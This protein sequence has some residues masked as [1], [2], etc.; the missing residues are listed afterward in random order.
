[1]NANISSFIKD[2]KGW[3]KANEKTSGLRA[4]SHT[5]ENI[6]SRTSS[7]SNFLSNQLNLSFPMLSK[8]KLSRIGLSHVSLEYRETKLSIMSLMIVSFLFTIFSIQDR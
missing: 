6:T 3:K 1:M 5:R 7:S 4:L 2:Q 8:S